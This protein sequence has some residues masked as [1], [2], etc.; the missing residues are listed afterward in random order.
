M[1]IF[2]Y[3][4][5]KEREREMESDH[6]FTTT[7]CFVTFI[8]T[9][10]LLR[11]LLF[12]SRISVSSVFLSRFRVS[13]SH[14]LPNYILIGD[15]DF[16]SFP[17]S[18]H[19]NVVQLLFESRLNWTPVDFALLIVQTGFTSS[20]PPAS[21]VSL[22][23]LLI[24]LFWSP[25][26][27]SYFNHCQREWVGWCIFPRLHFMDTSH[28]MPYYRLGSFVSSASSFAYQFKST[29]RWGWWSPSQY[30]SRQNKTQVQREKHRNKVRVI[31]HV[32][33]NF[34]NGSAVSPLPLF[35]ATLWGMA[36]I[37]ILS[38]S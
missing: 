7:P 15:R 32:N 20:P 23:A 22:L 38:S 27:Y 33:R 11:C 9:S 10:F 29:A 36:N 35:L 19:R 4:E 8:F 31:K 21:L 13:F 5:G 14:S 18:P 6:L 25:F 17:P 30:P 26:Y 28:P 34:R 2:I 16:S 3:G 24:L 37:M 12:D 1:I